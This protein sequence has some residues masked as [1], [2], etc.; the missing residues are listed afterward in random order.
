[1]PLLPQSFPKQG[2]TCWKCLIVSIRYGGLALVFAEA[3]GRRDVWKKA[4]AGWNMVESQQVLEW[5][6]EAKVAQQIKSLLELLTIR[7]PAGM[8]ADL[9]EKIQATSDLPTLERWFRAAITISS[10]D[11]LRR[12]LKA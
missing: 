2:L 9:T 6:A 3:A 11:D 4:L 7:F 5:Q 8:P 1:M 12:L 10:L